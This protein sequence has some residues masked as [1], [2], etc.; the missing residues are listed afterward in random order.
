VLL[1]L[2][3]Y[4]GH[5]VRDSGFLSSSFAFGA[6][7]GASLLLGGTVFMLRSSVFTY[8]SKILII[9]LWLVLAGYINDFFSESLCGDNIEGWKK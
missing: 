5:S 2:R 4:H 3:P 7:P 6:V 1:L 9:F 8:M